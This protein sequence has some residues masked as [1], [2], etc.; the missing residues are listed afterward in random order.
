MKGFNIVLTTMVSLAVLS[1]SSPALA[2]DA[3][4]PT[5]KKIADS[6][7]I[8]VGHRTSSVPF[9]YYDNDQKVVGF[10][11]DICDRIV[12]EVKKT[13]KRPDL[14]VKMV[15]TTSQNWITLVQNGTLDLV[16]GTTSNLR[17]RQEQ[18]A[19]ST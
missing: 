16:C 13:T 19:F 18:V 5:L 11:Q 2:A 3:A 10:A 15:P 7:V 14:Q 12:D 17:S 8:A 6:A 1:V 9:S 4:S